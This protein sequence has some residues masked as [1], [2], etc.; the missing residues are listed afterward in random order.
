MNKIYINLKEVIHDAATYLLEHGEITN[1]TSWQGKVDDKFSTLEVMNY[2]FICPIS[3]SIEVLEDQINP[4]LP[5]ARDHFLERVGG[6]PTNPGV[7]YMNWP[8]YKEERGMKEV[9][10]EE[11]SH[12]YQER[13]WCPPRPGIRYAWG[14]LSDVIG[15]LMRDPMTRQAVLPVFFPE[16]TGAGGEIPRRVPCSLHYC[17]LVRDKR[18]NGFYA[19]RSCD[20]LR[21]LNDDIYL[22]ARLVLWVLDQ[23][24]LRSPEFWGEVSPGF[25][26]THIYS[27][28]IFQEDLPALKYRLEGRNK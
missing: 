4:N 8:F 5:W 22:A 18:L 15:L 12:T 24:K 26:S 21:H 9:G 28:H 19:I 1:T 23:L 7:T 13:F 17:F 6:K 16:D 2:S 25:L 27:L 11:F 14:N 10:G 20:A 3:S